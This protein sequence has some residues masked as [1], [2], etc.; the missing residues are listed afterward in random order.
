MKDAFNT[1][2]DTQVGKIALSVLTA[3]AG[4][5]GIWLFVKNTIGNIP[6]IGG[7]A[8]PVI[9]SMASLA[10]MIGIGIVAYGAFQ[11]NGNALTKEAALAENNS[12]ENDAPNVH[13]HASTVGADVQL[14]RNPA[15]DANVGSN[16]KKTARNS[17]ALLHPALNDNIDAITPAS[18]LENRDAA[19][20]QGPS[21]SF[22][23]S[24]A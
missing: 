11:G 8:A 10:A 15:L 6:G 21:Y 12:Q 3:G 17:N 7:F 22:S 24:L 19:I 1:A 18:I 14:G 5:A 2:K 23:H 4:A 16:L 20:D 9:G 13:L